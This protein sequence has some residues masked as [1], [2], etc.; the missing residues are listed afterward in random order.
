MYQLASL[1]NKTVML[2]AS[3]VINNLIDEWKSDKNKSLIQL[4]VADLGGS[5]TGKCFDTF[6]LNG[7]NVT[8][9]AYYNTPAGGAGGLLNN[10]VRK[11]AVSISNCSE[12]GFTS[13]TNF[14]AQSQRP[15]SNDNFTFRMYTCDPNNNPC[16][17]SAI[18]AAGF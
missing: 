6:Q 18:T 1:K 16:T 13:G 9:T 10:N 17:K 4:D 8:P 3:L 15:N 2:S 12:L 14:G 7:G 5:Y 11:Y